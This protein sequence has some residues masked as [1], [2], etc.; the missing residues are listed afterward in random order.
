M[1]NSNLYQI[2]D[3]PGTYSIMSDSEEEEIARDYICFE[4]N[5]CT[6]IVVDATRLEELK[7]SK[8]NFRNDR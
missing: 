3:L 1:Y 5:D 7:F 6:V 4:G 2:I 8:A